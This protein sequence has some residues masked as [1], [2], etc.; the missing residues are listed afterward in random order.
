MLQQEI[1]MSDLTP[2][3]PVA[4]RGRTG[5]GPRP[6]ARLTV[7]DLMTRDTVTLEASRPIEEAISL[8]AG[9]QFRH[10][11]VVDGERLVGV[12]SDRDVLRA[13]VR[14]QDVASPVSGIM[15]GEPVHVRPELALGDAI[16]LLLEHRINCLPVTRE[17]DVLVGILTTTDLLRALLTIEADASASASQP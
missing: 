14:S 17:P 1:S 5:A 2:S 16:R 13:L 8:L 4:E 7:G 12:L 10:I 11:P 6:S 3:G 15:R 9:R